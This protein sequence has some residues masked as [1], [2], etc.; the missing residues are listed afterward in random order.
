MIPMLTLLAESKTMLGEQPA[1]SME[2]FSAHKP[3]LEEEAVKIMSF[4]E[5]KT[6]S[7]ISEGLGVSQQLGI[8]VHDLAYDF[9]HKLTGYKAIYGFTGEA[10][11]G[12]D[13]KT[14]S[15]EALEKAGKELKFISSVYGILNAEDIIKPYRFEFN[16]PFTASNK[17]PIQIF[18]PKVTIEL[19]KFIK[20]NEV[21]DII[22]LLPGDADKCIDWKIVRA[23][24]KVHKVCFQELTP[25]GKLKT[26]IAKTLKEMRGRM[27]RQILTDGIES[28]K[29]LISKESDH[30]MYSEEYSKTG[31]PVFLIG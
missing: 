17:S 20:E 14:L 21:N 15:P 31:L 22:D 12:L 27:A 2:E 24:S 8:K 5:T 3:I 16:K 6:S 29:D 9:P 19:V 28:F 1:V 4:I 23:F 25:E 30:Y 7:E 26:P 10:F 11:K 13:A 18:K